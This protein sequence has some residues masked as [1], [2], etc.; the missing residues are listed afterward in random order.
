MKHFS[1]LKF[2]IQSHFKYLPFLT[3]LFPRGKVAGAFELTQMLVEAFNNAVLHAHRKDVK[4]WIGIDIACH[5]KKT[6]IRVMDEGKGISHKS[7]IPS[8]QK[9]KIK[10]RGLALIAH[11]ADQIRHYQRGKKHILEVTKNHPKGMVPK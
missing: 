2:E 7:W 5:R 11:H 9:W 1:H 8:Q 10:G 6:R 3:Q 4:K